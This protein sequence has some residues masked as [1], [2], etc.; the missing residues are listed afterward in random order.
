M[1]MQVDPG[2]ADAPGGSRDGRS[3]TLRRERRAVVVVDLV[4]SVRL[5]EANEIDAI[6]RWIAFV[7][8]TRAEVL[9]AT[10]G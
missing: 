3:G 5:M 10:G 4:E 7:R 2:A 6:E 9:P 1:H 8:A